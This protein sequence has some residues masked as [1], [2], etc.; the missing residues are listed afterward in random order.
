MKFQ[1]FIRS[2]KRRADNNLRDNNMQ[3]DFWT[4]SPES[5]HQVAWLFG[6]RGI[7]A[8]WRH[9]SEAACVTGARR[10]GQPLSDA[11]LDVLAQLGVDVLPVLEHVR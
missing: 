1:H 6:D 8:T 11:F 2:Q 4:L 5:A 10:P 3:W 9:G 7:P